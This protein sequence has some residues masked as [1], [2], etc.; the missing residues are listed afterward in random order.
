MLDELEIPVWQLDQVRRLCN[1]WLAKFLRLYR[2]V[3]AVEGL[4]MM[5][6]GDVGR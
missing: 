4:R 3:K 6:K 1:Q 5:E 2:W